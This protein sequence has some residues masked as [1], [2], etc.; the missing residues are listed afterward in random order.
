MTA[1][2]VEGLAEDFPGL[3]GAALELARL[4]PSS[5][6][7]SFSD[8]WK[9]HFALFIE[10]A[11]GSPL[12]E[13]SAETILGVSAQRPRGDWLFDGSDPGDL[14]E[15][16]YY[17]DDVFEPGVIYAALHT[18]QGGGNR[19]CYCDDSSEGYHEAGCLA[20]NNEL[21]TEHEGYLFDFDDSFDSTYA[22]FVFRTKLTPKD[23]EELDGLRRHIA[24]VRSEKSLIDQINGGKLAPWIIL[25][26][27]APRD[28][29][30]ELAAARRALSSAEY[31]FKPDVLDFTE[32]LVSV[33]ERLIAGEVVPE[34]EIAERFGD[35]T[36]YDIQRKIQN[37][38]YQATQILDR[39]RSAARS[40][41]TLVH[42]RGMVEEAES[43]PAD[44]KL[45][46]YLLGDRGQ[47]SYNTTE[48]RGRRNVTVRKIYDRGSKLGEKLKSAD[49]VAGD[50][51]KRLQ[52]P[53]IDVREI[54]A[55]QLESKAKIE[56]LKLQI[57]ELEK[58]S[59]AAG[60][61]GALEDLPAR[62][63]ESVEDDDSIWD[64]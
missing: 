47:G 30:S 11:N 51:L 60:W 4:T 57:V 32:A 41:S 42:M 64:L 2:T 14:L 44:S 37:R 8:H 9:S 33:G 7:K 16:T 61:P 21:L 40:A 46:K 49:R 25:G 52:G 5:A 55:K 36:S 3:T 27:E 45:A 15:D 58:L 22:T 56:E 28:V 17:S 10:S 43:L 39:I 18:R 54:A 50:D 53:L 24:K 35:L 26:T 19:D 29:S 23:V 34:S 31:S 59:W 48:K 62:P 63:S 20:V 38:D 12:V 13:P 6:G 1:E